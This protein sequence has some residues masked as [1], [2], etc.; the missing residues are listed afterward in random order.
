MNKMIPTKT[1]RFYLFPLLRTRSHPRLVR[2]E[3]GV[4]LYYQRRL[5]S[6]LLQMVVSKRAGYKPIRNYSVQTHTAISSCLTWSFFEAASANLGTGTSLLKTKLELIA[7][8]R[9]TSAIWYP[10]ATNPDTAIPTEPLTENTFSCRVASSDELRFNAA[11]TMQ[12]EPFDNSFSEMN[13]GY[14]STS[15]FAGDNCTTLCDSLN[16]IFGQRWKFDEI[17]ITKRTL[18]LMQ[19]TVRTPTE[20]VLSR[21]CK[22]STIKTFSLRTWSYWFRNI[23]S[24]Q[25]DLIFS[26]LLCRVAPWRQV[27]Q[28]LAMRLP[29]RRYRPTY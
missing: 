15:Y 25:V 6:L 16:C 14:I 18:D 19:A 9:N 23:P 12:F 11:M 17:E 13:S 28:H 2:A 20:N 22:Y 24:S 3:K 26:L 29:E 8:F 7:V 10:S 4:L 1:S 27:Q 5:E 21:L